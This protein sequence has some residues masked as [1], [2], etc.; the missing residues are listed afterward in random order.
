VSRRFWR[1][2]RSEVRALTPDGSRPAGAAFP[3]RRKGRL[4][5]GTVPTSPLS[6]AT[7][8]PKRRPRS[9]IRTL[10]LFAGAGGLTTGLRT[11]S[12]RFRPVKAVEWDKAAAATFALN[13]G[14]KLEGDVLTSRAVHAGG[15]AEWLD[16]DDVP[17]VDVV[18]G[19][20]PCQGFSTLGKQDV[21]DSRNL[22]WHEYAKT[23]NR[24]RPS[25]FVLENVPAFLKSP[26][27]DVFLDELG[28]GGL[29]EEYSF[30][31]RVLNAADF[32]A[33]QARKRVVVIGHHK[34]LPAPGFPAATHAG[35][36]LRLSDVWQGVP[37]DVTTTGLD[38]GLVTFDGKQLAGPY[39]SRELHVGRNYQQIS[40]DRFKVIPAGGNRFDLPDDLKSPCWRK[41]TSGSGDVM[42]RLHW[43]R[44]S[45]TIRTEFFKPE[46]G[47]Y[48]HP[49]E[50]RVITHYEA[51]L[52][53]GFPVDYQWIGS[54]AD[55]ARQIGNA[56]PI[57]L[58]AAIGRHLRD[59]LD[60]STAGPS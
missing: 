36:H 27:Y 55:I 42:G 54:W 40:L 49:D 57:P 26:Q 16:Q 3:P 60:A 1:D 53:Q 20:P 39:S 38:G 11:A 32:G 45:V 59:A 4:S 17:K 13:H 19:G 46:K 43:D 52:I 48:L 24:A 23:V 15:I 21:D 6:A 29:L 5:S 9:Q 18:V 8:R 31:A 22:M 7:E 56:V 35:N 14:G 41:H 12:T 58:G 28:P 33:A 2:N 50:D 47:R 51:A 34:D 10:D 37:V 44:P 30:E 25:Y